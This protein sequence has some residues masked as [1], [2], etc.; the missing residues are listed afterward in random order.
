L[1][2]HRCQSSVRLRRGPRPSRRPCPR[3]FPATRRRR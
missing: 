3:A 2:C 1:A